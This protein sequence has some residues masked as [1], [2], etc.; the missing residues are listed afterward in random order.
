MP[1]AGTLEPGV[2]NAFRFKCTLPYSPWRRGPGSNGGGVKGEG[3]L[4]FLRG[5]ELG[6]ATIL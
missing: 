6:P 1:E 3:R 2:A 5:E 4:P